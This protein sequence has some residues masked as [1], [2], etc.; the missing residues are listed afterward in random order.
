MKFTGERH[1]LVLELILAKGPAADLIRACVFLRLL[2]ALFLSRGLLAL[3]GCVLL[4]VSYSS[5]RSPFVVANC[6]TRSF[7]CPDSRHGDVSPHYGHSAGSDI[8]SR[9]RF[10]KGDPDGVVRDEC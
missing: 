3:S 2:R 7:P 9:E 10:A 5:L 6:S 1:L 8:H 4:R